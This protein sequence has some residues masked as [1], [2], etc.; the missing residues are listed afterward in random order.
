M[1]VRPAVSGRP[2]FATMA[3]VSLLG[4]CSAPAG[5]CACAGF[6]ALPQGS[7]AGPKLDSAGAVRVSGGGL[8]VLNQNAS[9]ILQ[10]FA[11]GSQLVVPV[12]CSIEKVA[13]GAFPLLDLAIADTGSLYCT[14]ESCGRLDGRCD[15]RDL[16]QA[17]TVQ[18][19]DLAFSTAAPDRLEARITATVQTG[20]LPVSTV[21]RSSV[22]CLLS[23]GGPAKCT[24]D[25]DTTRAA[26]ADAQLT[27][28]IKL[29]VDPR[30]DKLLA[31]EVAD[32]GGAKACGSA[33]ARPPPACIDPN[34]IVI[35]NAGGCGACTGANLSI[36]KALLIDQLAKALKTQV[37]DALADANCA[38]CD[39]MTACPTSPTAT[40]SCDVDAGACVDTTTGR[41]VPALLGIEG[42]VDVAMTLGAFGAT[43]GAPLELSV[44]AG[45]GATATDAGVTV[46]LRGGFAAASVAPCVAHAMRPPQPALP[47]PDFDAR[48]PGPYAVG[49]SLSEQALSEALFQAQQSGALCLEL[50]TETIAALESSLLATL[51]PSLGLLT[52]GD[53]VPLRLVLRPVTAPFVTVGEGTVDANGAPLDPL[54]RL[55]W[56]ALELDLHAW[57]EERPVRLFTLVASM[58]LPLGLE[59]DGCAGVTPVIGSLRDAVVVTQVKNTELLAEPLG[60]LKALVPSLLAF[61]EPQLAQGL[62]AL[63]LPTVQGFGLKLLAARGIEPVAGTARFHHLALYADLTPPGQ[64]CTPTPRARAHRVARARSWAGDAV[65]VELPSGAR[66]SWRVNGG[67]W[68]PWTRVDSSGR[69]RVQHPRLLIDGAPVVEVRTDDGVL[70]Q[71]W[72]D[73]SARGP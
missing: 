57:I 19:A 51:L 69:L 60:A 40:A 37:G 21:S 16:G 36:I 29:T 34:D 42:R 56:P 49:V 61:A 38:P 26:S 14:D 46:G 30:W 39:A 3:L 52:H 9:S 64:A 41:C 70:A 35:A 1:S 5:G 67:F 50:G 48:A 4:A 44:G 58:D 27:L 20:P 13:I 53:N 23:G 31:L 8:A 72:L 68:S 62:S 17:L 18:I 6:T 43:A 11:P 7:Y 33:G 22:L 2:P 59:L 10:L 24:V 25:L 71:A 12:P 15:G 63:T 66:V 28:S 32:V 73:P 65:D 45:G 55:Q 47:L 54:L